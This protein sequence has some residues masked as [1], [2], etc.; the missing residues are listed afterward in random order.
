MRLL[1]R[2]PILIVIIYRQVNYHF[3][4]SIW[5]FPAFP[6][7]IITTSFTFIITTTSTATGAL[8]YFLSFFPTSEKPNLITL[9][10]PKLFNRRYRMYAISDPI[11]PNLAHSILPCFSLSVLLP[12]WRIYNNSVA[13]VSVNNASSDIGWIPFVRDTST[14]QIC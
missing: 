4:F 8:R 11:K 14:K 13:V 2:A 6:F 3:A 1:R 10:P 12:S 7:F 5:H 9:Y